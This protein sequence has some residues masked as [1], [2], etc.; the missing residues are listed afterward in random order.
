MEIDLVYMWVDGSDPV[1]LAK[2]RALTGEMA[3]G[4]EANSKARYENNDELKYSLRS[5]EKNAPWI[6]RIFIVTDGQT[7][8]WLDTSDPRIRV[9]DHSEIM[10]PEAL[11]CFNASVI[12]YELPGFVAVWACEFDDFH[13]ASFCRCRA[14]SASH[15]R[16]CIIHV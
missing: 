10:P 2:K 5:A 16:S 8:E 3:E 1:W 15:F 13:V 14:V 6:R 7:P 4:G 9:V 12:N 11:P